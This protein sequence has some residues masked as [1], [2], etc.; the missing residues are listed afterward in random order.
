M[1]GT[2]LVRFRLALWLALASDAV[3]APSAPKSTP[4]PYT[5]Y[6]HRGCLPLIL[7]RRSVC[8]TECDQPS[9]VCGTEPAYVPFGA[10]LSLRVRRL[11]RY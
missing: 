10:V 11:E 1:S 5:L 3:P 4:F 6:Q 8:G 9:C 2:D 7:P